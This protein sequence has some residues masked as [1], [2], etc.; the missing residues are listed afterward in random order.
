MEI[1]TKALSDRDWIGA[2]RQRLAAAAARLD[3]L[4][5][6][7]GLDVIGGTTLYRLVETTHAGALHHGLAT[8]GSHGRD[9]LVSFGDAG[10]GSCTGSIRTSATGPS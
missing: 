2:T 5:S 6:G 8:R 1:A 3:R 4:L 9:H 10:A 7:H